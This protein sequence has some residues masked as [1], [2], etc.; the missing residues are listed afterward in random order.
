[1]T[2]TTYAALGFT[3]ITFEGGSKLTYNHNTNNINY[4]S[5]TGAS[6]D[7]PYDPDGEWFEMMD[8]YNL[9]K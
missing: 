2:K 1:M 5:S 3:I 7:V 6:Y 8:R 9:W 4:K